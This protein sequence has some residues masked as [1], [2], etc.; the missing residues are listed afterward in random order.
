MTRLS[1]P[2][3]PAGL[4]PMLNPKSMKPS[5][6][7]LCHAKSAATPRIARGSLRQRSEIN[8][9]DTHRVS[10]GVMLILREVPVFEV[11]KVDTTQAIRLRE[12]ALPSGE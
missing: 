10:S 12:S 1:R 4:T 2:R 5:Y 9:Q 7:Q 6:G 8:A 3:G 11:V